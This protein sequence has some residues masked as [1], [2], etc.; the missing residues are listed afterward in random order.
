MGKVTIGDDERYLHPLVCRQNRNRVRKL[1][2]SGSTTLSTNRRC[3][4]NAD[5]ESSVR[6]EHSPGAVDEQSDDLILFLQLMRAT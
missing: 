2:R 4:Y 5:E 1:K 3:S 6:W